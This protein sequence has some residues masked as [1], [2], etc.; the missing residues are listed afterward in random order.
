MLRYSTTFSHL[1]RE[2]ALIAYLEEGDNLPR[3]STVAFDQPTYHSPT[4]D[5][6]SRK[7]VIFSYSES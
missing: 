1:G 3:A 5:D 6:N 7:C 2:W 4:A